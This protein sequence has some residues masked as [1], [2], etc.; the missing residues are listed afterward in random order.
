[1]Y[2]QIYSELGDD[3]ED[4]DKQWTA[5]ACFLLRHGAD[6]YRANSKGERPVNYINSHAL[7]SALTASLPPPTNRPALS[8]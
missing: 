8:P 1:M 6:L 2:C 3:I 7:H 5:M 4:G